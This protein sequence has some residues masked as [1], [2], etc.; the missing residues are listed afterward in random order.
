M[1]GS[2]QQ[3]LQKY[4]QLLALVLS[5]GGS[6]TLQSVINTNDEL[7]G[8]PPNSGD[9]IIY[10]GTDVVWGTV[11][12]GSTVKASSVVIPAIDTTGTIPFGFTFSSVPTVTISQVSS[13]NIVGLSVVSTTTTGFTWNSTASGVG[14][15]NW[16][17]TL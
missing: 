8:S 13:G 10:N 7:Q 6:G 16:I 9:A 2:Y 15:I 4:N 5:G 14:N 17:A 11:A 12:G 1:S 3:L